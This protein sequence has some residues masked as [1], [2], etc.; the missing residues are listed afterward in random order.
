MFVITGGLVSMTSDDEP[1]TGG[2]LTGASVGG[3]LGSA[4]AVM[5]GDSAIAESMV[6]GGDGNEL[7]KTI[8]ESI[9]AGSS[10]TPRMKTGLPNF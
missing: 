4:A 7:T 5:L 2:L 6:G 9:G 8:M 3:I 1:T 10:S